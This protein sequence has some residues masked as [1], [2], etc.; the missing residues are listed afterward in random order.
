MSAYGKPT[1]VEIASLKKT[2]TSYNVMLPGSGTPWEDRGAIGVISAFFKTSLR[3]L[4]HYRALVDQIRRPETTGETT[5]FALICGG[6]W[7]VSIGVWDA[8]QYHRF[9]ND[10]MVLV[11]QSQYFMEMI[12]RV[13]GAVALTFVVLKI[14]TAVFYNLL[15]HDSQR[16]I[17]QVLVQ[18]VFAYALGASI[19]ALVPVFGWALAAMWIVINAIVGAK[20]RLYIK[21]REA[22]VN[23]GIAVV[24]NVLLLAAIYTACYFIVPAVYGQHSV[25]HIEVAPKAMMN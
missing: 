10:G 2:E 13:V 8:Y 16:Q 18:N 7:A 14:T 17:P 4:F 21:G 3:S 15:S 19:L 11:A 6:L 23:V 1:E 24:V 9:S 25:N 20:S 5:A 22:V 12:L